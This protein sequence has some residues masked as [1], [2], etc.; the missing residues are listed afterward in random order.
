MLAGFYII[1]VGCYLSF[2]RF[3]CIRSCSGKKSSFFFFSMYTLLIAK[4]PK[5]FQSSQEVSCSL[6][7]C[8]ALELVPVLCS[9]VL[10][11]LLFHMLGTEMSESSLRNHSNWWFFGEVFTPP[12]EMGRTSN[13]PLYT[14]LQVQ[15]VCWLEITSWFLSCGITLFEDFGLTE[16]SW[17]CTAKNN[18]VDEFLIYVYGCFALAFSK[19][20]RSSS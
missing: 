1:I 18:T 5:T 15:E 3:V 11:V 16:F 8:A 14:Y 2:S 19:T 7:F 17:V 6:F 9:I 12:H 10:P 4:K 13:L 20:R